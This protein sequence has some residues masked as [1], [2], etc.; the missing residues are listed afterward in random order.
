[1]KLDTAIKRQIE[2]VEKV[3]SLR[4]EVR[5]Y[6]DTH[7]KILER[8]NTRIYSDSRYQK[9]PA[10]CREHIR[11]YIFGWLDILWGEMVPVYLDLRTSTH[12]IGKYPCEPQF[13]TY[14]GNA[15]NV[16]NSQKIHWFSKRSIED[17]AEEKHKRNIPAGIIGEGNER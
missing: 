17:I 14:A 4:W 10:H 13:F 3:K 16:D 15:W 6:L 9:L 5:H 12:Y 11:G 2:F 7:E 8:L 1:M